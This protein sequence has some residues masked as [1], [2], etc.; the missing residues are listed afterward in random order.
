MT[1]PAERT[2]SYV[3][4]PANF[5]PG[6]GYKRAK[7]LKEALRYCRQYGKGAEIDRCIYKR[8]RK[9]ESEFYHIYEDRFVYNGG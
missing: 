6:R 4:Y 7:N 2:I 5:K 3:V 9:G 1:K 8:N